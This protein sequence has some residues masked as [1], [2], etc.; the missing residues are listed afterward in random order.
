MDIKQ[1][2]V[3]VTIAFVLYIVGLLCSRRYDYVSAEMFFGFGLALDGWG[4]WSMYQN[5]NAIPCNF[6]TVIGGISLFLMLLLVIVGGLG[7]LLYS[8]KLLEGFR[9][10]APYACGVWALNFFSGMLSH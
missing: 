8:T 3:V 9:K 10:F 6:H 1:A 7:L 5:T 4:S 2:V